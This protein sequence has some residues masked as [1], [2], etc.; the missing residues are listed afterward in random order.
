MHNF[1]HQLEMARPENV[2]FIREKTSQSAAAVFKAGLVTAHAEG[3]VAVECF[4]A[5]FAEQPNE[6]RISAFV[7]HDET[8]VDRPRAAAGL[9]L[10]SVGVPPQPVL[11]LE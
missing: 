4:D 9:D 7:V 2:S 10:M 1:R 6:V 5:E 3:H 8:G 11:S